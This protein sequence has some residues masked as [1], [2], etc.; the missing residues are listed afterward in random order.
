MG[1]KLP[2]KFQKKAAEAIADMAGK[3]QELGW[4]PNTPPEESKKA[5][6]E[7]KFV[8]AKLDR[9]WGPWKRKGGRGNDGGF[10]LRWGAEKVGFGEFTFYIK[11]KKVICETE[12]MGQSFVRGA[13]EHFLRT[14]VV[15][16]NR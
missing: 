9:V 16:E 2:K 1:K 8:Y 5:M 10:V 7:P 4:S 14:S 15:F 6:D 12:C 13:F 11:K 3:A